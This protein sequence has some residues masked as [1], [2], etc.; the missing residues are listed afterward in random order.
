MNLLHE[1]A[2]Q[3]LLGTERR[4]PVLPQV[5][6][7]LGDLL[8]ACCPHDTELEVRILRSAGAMAI[9][10][11]AGFVPADAGQD[12]PEPCPPEDLQPVADPSLRSVLHRI[13]DDG[14]DPLRREAMQ[15]LA[16]KGA[17]LPP[18]LLPR[19]L[20]L[21]QKTPELRSV[22]LPVLGQRGLWLAKLNPSWSY[23]VG[24]LGPAL[25]MTFWEDG[26][27][28]QR[29]QFLGRLRETDP[30][31]ARGCLQEQFAELD[32]R[33]RASLL[34]QMNIGLNP[35]DEEFL[36]ALLADRSKEVRQLAASL[37]ARLPTSGYGVRMAERLSAC[38]KQERKLF[39]QVLT[40]EAPE[41]FCADWKADA[42]EE[43]RSKSESL[44]ERAWWLYQIARAVPLAW[45]PA[46]TGM[47]TAELIKWVRGT[48]WSEAILRAWSEALMRQPDADWAAA[49]LDNPATVGPEIDVFD[50][51]ACLPLSERE[52]HWLRMLDAAP[53]YIARGD[54]LGRIADAFTTGS[55]ELSEGFA[56][57]VLRE[58]RAT[59]HTD[60]SKGDY[61]LRKSLPEFVCLVPPACFPDAVEGWPAGQPE[62]E[63]FSETLAR[64]LV[65]VE[66]RK[67]L[68]RILS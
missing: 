49:F 43:A 37:L 52:Q 2:S 40:L 9:C 60:A 17:C 58:V 3:V 1:L 53:R 12:L 63:Y 62:T 44:G 32:A 19:T 30:G 68:Y 8:N 13:I 56:R 46:K 66:Q 61:A 23:A 59:L 33:E 5:S 27:L 38:L 29:K 67:T 47:A 25:D 45:W 48:D 42:L 15:K 4:P 10:A 39:R 28:E 51:L 7:A 11:D 54:L 31:K 21:G 64:V 20:S 24:G 55:Q 6:G 50:L 57:R 36:E 22:L 41:H 34:A 65:I 18:R 14:P 16:M 35:S 26:T